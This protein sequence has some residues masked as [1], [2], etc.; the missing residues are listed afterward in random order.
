MLSVPWTII[1]ARH[2]TRLGYKPAQIHMNVQTLSHTHIPD[3][4]P[5][6][7]EGSTDGR[8]GHFRSQNVTTTETTMSNSDKPKRR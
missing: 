6:R 2:D 4:T 8:D 1:S 5:L 7:G 3:S